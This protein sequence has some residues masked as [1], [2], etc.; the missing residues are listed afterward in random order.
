MNGLK[1]YAVALAV[2][3]AAVSHGASLYAGTAFF[4]IPPMTQ[5]GT[6]V[7]QLAINQMP[8]GYMVAGQFQISVPAGVVSGTL[9][10]FQVKRLL[11]PTFGSQSM[12]LQ[13]YIV[14]FSQPS[15]FGTFGNTLGYCK[16]YLDVTGFNTNTNLSLN[17]GAATWNVNSTSGTFNYVS[18][19][20]VYLVQDFELDGYKTGGPAGTWVVDLPLTAELVPEPSSIA[21]LLFL[22][23]GWRHRPVCVR[24]NKS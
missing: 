15:A 6:A 24:R 1:G 13:H 5:M 23:L 17:A 10:K 12:F 7:N 19:T 9:L 4:S 22:G 21:C 14:G 8:T 18:G 16:T 11:N 2:A 3:G 20:D